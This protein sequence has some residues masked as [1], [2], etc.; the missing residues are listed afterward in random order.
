VRDVGADGLLLVA[1]PRD[2]PLVVL[3][4][5]GDVELGALVAAGGG[6][7]RRREEG[8]VAVELVLVVEEAAADAVE[9]RQPRLAVDGLDSFAR[10]GGVPQPLR[11][12]AEPDRL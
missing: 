6:E 3:E 8:A 12:A 1:G 9:L 5:A 10:V 4:Q 11:E 7:G 2:D